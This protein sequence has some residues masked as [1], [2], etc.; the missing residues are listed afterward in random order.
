MC[1]RRNLHG[2]S[3]EV[4]V[5]LQHHPAS[6]RHMRTSEQDQETKRDII[7]RNT[8]IEMPHLRQATSAIATTDSLWS[9]R[10]SLEDDRRERVRRYLTAFVGFPK[11]AHSRISCFGVAST[12][13]LAKRDP[14]DVSGAGPWLQIRR[15]LAIPTNKNAAPKVSWLRTCR[16]IVGAR[17]TAK[18]MEQIPAFAIGHRCAPMLCRPAMRRSGMKFEFNV[19]LRSPCWDDS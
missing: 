19:H 8:T 9:D 5:G 16:I 13:L 14:F 4:G 11:H 1:K 17:P 3:V 6:D 15:S 7:R 12:V 10:R 18:T 2:A